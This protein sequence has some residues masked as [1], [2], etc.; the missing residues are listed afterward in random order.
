ME[1]LYFFEKLRMPVLNELMLVI[2][3]FGEETALLVIALIVF[4]CIDKRQGYYIL[5]V[6]LLGTMANQVLKL[7]CRV[8]RPW[9]LD[10]S[11]TILEE[12]REAATGYSFPS[13]HTQTAVGTFGALA[14]TTKQKVVRTICIVIAVLVPISRMYVGVHT[15]LDVTVGAVMALALVFLLKK[16]VYG[17]EGKYIPV[18]L[19]A[20][21]GISVA[22]LL[23][24]ELWPFPADMDAA[25]LASGLKNAYTMIGCTVG[26]LLCY[27]LDKKY[28]QFSVKAVWW[29]Q[30]L[31]VV[32]GLAVVLLVKEGLR[33]PLDAL[34]AGHLAARA[35]RYFLIVVV[36][37]VLWPL[38]FGL[39]ARLGNRK[40][41]E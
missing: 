31:K 29:V 33:S 30:I 11:F 25:N 27:A 26:L 5:G 34:F 17:N 39:L 22:F 23:F 41:G 15:L 38:S 8:P 2:T 36:A 1:I 37:G 32:L 3:R 7:L 20:M 6:G 16:V 9:V 19:V 21:V 18:M 35:V 40:K 12:A 4:W 14:V 24:A 28:I 10:K 13:G